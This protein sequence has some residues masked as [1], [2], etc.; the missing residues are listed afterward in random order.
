[1]TVEDWAEYGIGSPDENGIYPDYRMPPAA[2]RPEPVAT[3]TAAATE[4][5]I[6]RSWLAIV[7]HWRLVVADLAEIYHLDLYD[8]A[9]RARPWMG[10]RTMI[11]ALLESPDS[12]LRRAL[13]RR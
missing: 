7:T 9:V 13:T 10:V 1:M 12:R 8:P 2:V 5:E 11:F 3:V 6:D 4:P